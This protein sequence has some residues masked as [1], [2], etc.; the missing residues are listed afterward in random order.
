MTE[1][2]SASPPPDTHRSGFVA[3]CGRP[4]VGKSSLLNALVGE[5]IAVATAQPQTTRERFLGIWTRPHFQV[6]LVDTPGIHRAR[7]ALNRYMVAQAQIATRDVDLILLLAEAPVVPDLAAAE[8]WTPGEVALEA[9]ETV[10]HSR[11]PIVLVITKVDRLEPRELLAPVLRTWSERHEFAALV[12][13][14]SVTQEGLAA[15]EAIILERLPL[16]PRYYDEDDLSVRT[17]RWHAAELIRAELFAQLRE[18]LPYSCA[19]R[20]VRYE[21]RPDR[22]AIAA[23]IFVERDS[24]KGMVIGR[25]A[26]TIR[27]ISQASRVRISD[28]TGRPC[29]LRLEVEVAKNWTRD[30][31][32]LGQMGYRDPE[33][34]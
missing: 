32:K 6:V 2:P 12:P 4:N 24:Q 19:V 1:G 3:L 29:D 17:T 13:T 30:P 5:P 9:L 8:A 26:Q 10:A 25:G 21:E 22:D 34:S 16:G 7:S 11:S 18:E 27:S 23:T 15:L 33:G 31:E 20:I 14:S 28:L